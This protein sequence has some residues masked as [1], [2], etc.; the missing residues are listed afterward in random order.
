MGYLIFLCLSDPQELAAF[1]LAQQ[2]AHRP[3]PELAPGRLFEAL[4]HWAIADYQV[5]VVVFQSQGSQRLNDK[6]NFDY[7]P[8]SDVAD[9]SLGQ[10]LL[11]F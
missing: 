8:Y 2:N 1:Q 6:R 5:V 4:L 9:N 11:L 7:H 3:E 10:Q